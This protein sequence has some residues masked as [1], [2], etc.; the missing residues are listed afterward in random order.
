V[1]ARVSGAFCFLCQR[2]NA[3]GSINSQCNSSLN[4]WHHV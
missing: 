2:E 4:P 3:H 1:L